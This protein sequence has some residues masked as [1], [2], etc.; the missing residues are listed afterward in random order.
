MGGVES[1]PDMRLDIFG[2]VFAA[3]YEIGGK[4]A[5]EA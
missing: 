4:I 5:A 2:V 1:V 3:A